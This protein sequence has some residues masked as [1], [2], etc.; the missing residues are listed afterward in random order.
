[1][2]CSPPSFLYLFARLWLWGLWRWASHRN[3]SVVRAYWQMSPHFSA[4]HSCQ[5][6]KKPSH[7]QCQKKGW[8]WVTSHPSSPKP[9]CCS[10]LTTIFLVTS[11]THMHTLLCHCWGQRRGGSGRQKGEAPPAPW[12]HPHLPLGSAWGSC[13]THAPITMLHLL[14]TSPLGTA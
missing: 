9:Y 3:S 8:Y 7:F 13:P 5:I 4:R 14:Y 11:V 6:G 1:M 10:C 2:G 12:W